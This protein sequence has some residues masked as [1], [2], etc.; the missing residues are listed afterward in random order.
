MSLRYP[1]AVA[2]TAALMMAVAGGC[3]KKAAPAPV[4]PPLARVGEVVITEEDVHFEIERRRATGRPLGEVETIVQDLI[5]REAMLQ[6][7]AA[8]EIMKDPQVQR[9]LENRTL[10]QWL[11]RSLQVERDAVRVTDEDMQAHYQANLDAYTRPEMTRFAML[12][13]RISSRDPENDAETLANEL[14][15]ARTAF[16]ADPGTPVQ[17]GQAPGFGPLAAEVS[18]DTVSRYRGG[19]LGWL[20]PAAISNRLPAAIAEKAAALE[21]GAISDV[22]IAEGGVYVLMKTDAR[23]AQITPYEE[24]APALRR[25]LIRLKQEE[26]ERTFMSNLLAETRIELNQER[27]AAITLPE[28]AA[29]EPPVLRPVPDVRST[30]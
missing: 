12:F 23:P 29:L 20:D 28:P 13:R 25:R 16:L 24:I 30:P 11:D 26:V 14:Q 17:A 4:E 19:D 15:A 21:V 10:G 6:K 5:E 3:G 7:A 22:L 18:E 8:S 1:G 27:V 2:V 9:E